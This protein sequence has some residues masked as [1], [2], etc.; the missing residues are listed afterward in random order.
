MS[1]NGS[2][3]TGAD[4]LRRDDAPAATPTPPALKAVGGVAGW[5][6]DRTGASKPVGYLMKKV[7]PEHWS[8]M[9]GEIAMYSM[10]LFMVDTS[11]SGLSGSGAMPT[12]AVER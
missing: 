1:S 11:L 12:D 8:F 6:D 7:F 4:R 5:F 2:R 9:L 3:S 10:I